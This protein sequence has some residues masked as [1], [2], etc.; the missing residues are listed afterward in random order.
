M[1]NYAHDKVKHWNYWN[2]NKLI[3]LLQTAVYLVKQ[4]GKNIEVWNLISDNKHI[5]Q[6][7]RNQDIFSIGSVLIKRS[8]I[9]DF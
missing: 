6:L 7:S 1:S 8:R 5:N 4:N 3:F 9:C 2:S